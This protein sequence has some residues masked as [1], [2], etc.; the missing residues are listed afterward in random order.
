L[1]GKVAQIFPSFLTGSFKEW[2]LALP[3]L[4]PGVR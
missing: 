2:N 4:G 3:D 1:S